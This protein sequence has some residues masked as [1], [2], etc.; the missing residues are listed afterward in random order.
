MNN[1]KN[2][3][4]QMREHFGWDQ[5]D[6]IQFLIDSLKEEVLELEESVNLS[7]EEFKDELA[8]V[9]MYALTIAFDEGY[10]IEEIINNKI[11]KV[12]LREY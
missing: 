2:S 12:M 4:E 7:E 10:D 6:S 1:I 11:K 5:T 3:I 9:L 8:D